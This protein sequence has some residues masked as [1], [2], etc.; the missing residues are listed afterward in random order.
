MKDHERIMLLSLCNDNYCIE[1]SS[2]IVVGTRIFIKEGPLMGK[3]SIIKRI[4]R[5]KR[6]AIIDL[7]CMGVLSQVHVGLEI[8]EKI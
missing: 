3:E 6:K 4:D 5:H 2:G 8:V 1:K 7:E